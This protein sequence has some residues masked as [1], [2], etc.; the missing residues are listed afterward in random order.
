[1]TIPTP[2]AV[3]SQAI[4]FAAH[5]VDF[6]DVTGKSLSILFSVIMF[7]GWY[8]NNRKKMW[9]RLGEWIDER[10]ARNGKDK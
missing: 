7:F 5:T 1:M 8:V 2:L 3:L 9:A 10:R 4:V 6:L